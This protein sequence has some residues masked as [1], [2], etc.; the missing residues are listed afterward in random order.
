MRIAILGAGKMGS[1]LAS[2]LS[3]GNEVALWDRKSSKSEA[4]VGVK[5]LKE[6][7]DR[8]ISSPRC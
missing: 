6:L 1:W 5:A 7:A 3:K 2:E 8:V 4:V